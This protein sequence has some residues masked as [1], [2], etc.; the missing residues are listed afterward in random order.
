MLRE[1]MARKSLFF[2]NYSQAIPAANALPSPDKFGYLLK[3]SGKGFLYPGSWKRKF[4][5]LKDTDLFYY[6][7]E[8]ST[9]MEKSCGVINLQCNNICR[10]A[11]G[12]DSKKAPNVFIIGGITDKSLFDSGK[13]L[14]SADTLMD[15]NDWIRSIQKSLARSRAKAENDESG[16]AEPVKPKAV[17]INEELIKQ[18]IA[19]EVP[20]TAQLYNLT[21]YRP[22]GPKGRRLPKR[23]YFFPRSRITYLDETDSQFLRPRGL[24]ANSLSVLETREDCFSDNSD[25]PNSMDI[26]PC[27]DESG[28]SSRQEFMYRYSSSEESLIHECLKEN[29]I[30]HNVQNLRS[31]GNVNGKRPP[32]PP[33]KHQQEEICPTTN[34]ELPWCREE[35]ATV[36]HHV[37][38]MEPHEAVADDKK[39]N[40][41]IRYINLRMSD[42]M[43][44]LATVKGDMST[45]QAEVGSLQCNVNNLQQGNGSATDRLDKMTSQIV[46]LECQLVSLLKDVESAVNKVEAIIDET[47]KAKS[48]HVLLKEEC[49]NMLTELQQTEDLYFTKKLNRTEDDDN[50]KQIDIFFLLSELLIDSN[51]HEIIQDLTE[52]DVDHRIKSFGLRLLG[53]K[54]TAASKMDETE[55]RSVNKLLLKLKK[56]IQNP[57]TPAV[58]KSSTL[59]MLRKLIGNEYAKDLI[60]KSGM[61]SLCV[62]LLSD[63][64]IFV[65]HEAELFLS[66][67][68]T[69]FL[70]R[71]DPVAVELLHQLLETFDKKNNSHFTHSIMILKRICETYFDSKIEVELFNLLLVET[72]EFICK[73]ICE[74]LVVIQVLRKDYS[75]VDDILKKLTSSDLIDVALM[76]CSDLLARDLPFDLTEKLESYLLLTMDTLNNNQNTGKNFETLSSTLLKLNIITLSDEFQVQYIQWMCNF[77]SQSQTEMPKLMLRI[78]TKL[79]TTYHHSNLDMRNLIKHTLINIINS[80]MVGDAV[81]MKTLTIYGQLCKDFNNIENIQKSMSCLL[82]HPNWAVQDSVLELIGQFIL[83]GTQESYDCVLS[84]KLHT[85]VWEKL[86]AENIESFI[87]ATG[88]TTM[89]NIIRVPELWQSLCATFDESKI[90]NQVLI[91]LGND[92]EVVVRRAATQTVFSL[93]KSGLISRKWKVQL[94]SSM[95]AAV[96]DLDWEVK[97]GALRF[98]KEILNDLHLENH[99]DIR[100]TVTRLDHLGFCF[101]LMNAIEDCDSTVRFEAASTLK[102]I[103]KELKK[104]KINYKNE[105]FFD[106]KQLKEASLEETNMADICKPL[107]DGVMESVLDMCDSEAVQ[108]TIRSSELIYKSCNIVE[109]D[110]VVFGCDRFMSALLDLDLDK[111]EMVA[112]ANSDIYEGNLELGSAIAKIV[113][114][115]AAKFDDFDNAVSMWVFE[116]IINERKLTEII[117]TD[118]E[119]VKYLPGHKLPSNVIA[120]PDLVDTCKDA[121]ILVFVI[122]HQFIRR[123][124]ET[125]DGKIKPSAFGISLIKGVDTTP[126]GIQLISKI[127]TDKLKIDMSVLMGA[128]IAHE[129][130]NENYCET[131]VG[132]KNKE[133][134]K[135]F[136]KLMEADYFRVVVVEDTATVEICGAL[137]NIV[138]CAAGFVDGM[139]L[140]DNTKAAVIRLGLMEMI[141]FTQSFFDGSKINTF[142]ESCGVADLITTCYGGRNRKV[143]E[144]FVKTG[145]TIEELEKE[146]LNGQKLQGPETAKDVNL[147]L[148]GKEMLEKFPLFVAVHRICIGEIPANSFIDQIRYH[149]E[150]TTP[151]KL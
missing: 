60:I 99:R 11:T 26:E 76:F 17:K 50:Y 134:G 15:M 19:M 146:M 114:A 8:D 107:D 79:S 91:F 24:R 111:V 119:N 63:C 84:N 115:N 129:V 140:G 23:K 4:C 25:M 42:L 145:K 97:L 2:S 77:I 34:S 10:E 18:Q 51:L 122:P 137:K 46:N 116:E 59:T 22:R 64:S 130:A 124:I 16:F 92:T 104:S 147:M 98:W 1:S 81:L 95:Q 78:L 27:S 110:V 72:D 70:P 132:S 31:G 125:L 38:V 58:I 109:K 35:R 113:G 131:T 48:Q 100:H 39:M 108:R 94:Q 5:V 20:E 135:L 14:F 88:L 138:A 117:N 150:H 149:P 32:P 68:L 33:I 29:V 57:T 75:K 142:L 86:T 139:G 21:K 128:N 90:I 66:E 44:N 9:G 83:D 53:L 141:K 37:C 55:M 123:T 133:Q 6:D 65:C 45:A 106:V 143:S 136:K 112:N 85:T 151:F 118:H 36:D 87:R 69:K 56:N 120:V 3:L 127:I 41:M 96:C 105:K 101:A 144:A 47:E 74:V 89:S 61:I 148:K 7:R 43:N 126:D 93:Y 103:E 13:Y 71:S 73:K 52:N 80:R 54:I 40:S 102:R 12:K 62:T 67:F 82:Y 30:E 28:R 121:D 49:E